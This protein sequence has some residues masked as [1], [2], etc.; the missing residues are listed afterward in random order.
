MLSVPQCFVRPNEIKKQADEA[1]ARFAHIDGDHLTLLNVYHAFKQNRDDPQWCYQNF[2]NFRSLKNADDVRTQL[3]RIMDKFNLKRVSADFNSRDYYINIRKALVAG[4]FMQVAHLER[5]GH[6]VTIKDNQIVNLHPSSVLDHKP[7]WAL[8]N[9]FVLTTKNYI[10]TVTDVRP[11]WLIQIAP[12]YYDVNSFPE[13]S[14]ARRKLN[15]I[16]A[17]S[18]Q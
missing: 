8:Y 2:I 6:Y 5:S 10:R 1:K 4:F 14:D 15:A 3:A 18:R 7:E 9:E 12:Q 17:A 16:I 13:G 11:E